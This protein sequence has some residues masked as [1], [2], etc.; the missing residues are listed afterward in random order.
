MTLPLDH[1]SNSTLTK[2]TLHLTSHCL[3]GICWWPAQSSQ[4][5]QPN[6]GARSGKMSALCRGRSAPLTCRH[7]HSHSSFATIR[8]SKS[9]HL[10]PVLIQRLHS[11]HPTSNRTRIPW[12]MFCCAALSLAARVNPLNM[13]HPPKHPPRGTVV[14][15]L[16]GCGGP[17]PIASLVNCRP[18]ECHP[19]HTFGQDSLC[20][21][22]EM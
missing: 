2:S 21:Q 4:K 18:L 19:P 6:V 8:M 9:C 11:G 5:H 3:T 12:R 15:V 7:S 1:H 20:G 10:L 17:S 16:V 14:Y 22:R 13:T